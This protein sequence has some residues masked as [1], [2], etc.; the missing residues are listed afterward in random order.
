MLVDVI[1]IRHQQAM[2]ESDRLGLQLLLRCLQTAE[3]L[4]VVRG[5][6]AGNALDLSNESDRLARLAE[7][8]C[9]QIGHAS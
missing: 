4:L 9:L 2:V 6:P 8:L 1:R 3:F 7:V 5:R